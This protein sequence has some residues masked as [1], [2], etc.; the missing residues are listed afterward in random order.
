ME[1]VL[2]FPIEHCRKGEPARQGHNCL[3]IPFPRLSQIVP[4]QRAPQKPARKDRHGRP[5]TLKD[6][7]HP[8]TPV[9]KRMELLLKELGEAWGEPVSWDYAAMKLERLTGI[10]RLESATVFELQKVMILLQTDITEAS[11]QAE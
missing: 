7:N 1:T 9:L 11:Q 2:R 4:G 3:V 6:A 10:N 5:A 8:A